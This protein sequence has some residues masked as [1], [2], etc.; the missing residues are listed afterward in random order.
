MLKNALPQSK[1]AVSFGGAVCLLLSI[2]NQSLSKKM[3]PEL[4]AAFDRILFAS[5]LKNSVTQLKKFVWIMN[6]LVFSTR[7]PRHRQHLLQQPRRPARLL[8][9]RNNFAARRRT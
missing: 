4:R 1:D 9:A 3:I 5:D 6:L 7:R 8:H 2:R